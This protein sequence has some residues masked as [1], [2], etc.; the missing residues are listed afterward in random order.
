[1]ISIIAAIAKNNAI[2]LN[3]N[4]LCHIPEDLKRFKKIT[5]SHK[6]FMGRKTFESLPKGAL[7]DRENIILTRRKNY[8]PH[9]CVVIHDIE[10]IKLYKDSKEEV[11][12]IGGEELYTQILPFA[13]KL[14]ITEIDEYY[15]ADTYFPDYNKD[16]WTGVTRGKSSHRG[17]SFSFIDY[18]RK[19]K[20][21]F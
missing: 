21:N 11:F 4:L 10:D 3:G 16:E 12:V 17:I 6:I 2:G 20:N 8:K 7:P 13:K 19:D 1:M 18:H 14:Y 9:N 15:E 5:D